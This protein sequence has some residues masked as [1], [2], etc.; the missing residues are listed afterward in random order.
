MYKKIPKSVFCK[1]YISLL[2]SLQ[3]VVAFTISTWQIKDVYPDVAYNIPL[4][5]VGFLL[6]FLALFSLITAFRRTFLIAFVYVLLL[7]SV[8]VI[9]YYELAL[10]GTVLTHQDIGNLTTAAGQ[11]NNYTF[12][13]TT[14]VMWILLSFLATQFFLL[15]IRTR[16]IEFEVNWKAG[17]I[18]GLGLVTIIY[19]LIYSPVSIIDKGNWSWERKFFIDSFIVGTLENIKVSS[20]IVQKPDGYSDESVLFSKD[21]Q[22]ANDKD[23]SY[24]DIIV[25]LNETYYD[26]NHL[27]DFESDVS[28]MENYDALDAYKGYAAVP[29]VGGGTNASEYELLTGNSMSLLNTSTPFN[30]MLFQGVH[31]MVSYLER[32][33]Y[34]TMAAHSE[35]SSNYHRGAA[36]IQLGFDEVFFSDDFIGLEKYGER[37]PS[38]DSSVFKN[39]IRFYNEMPD[40]KP[41]FAYLLTIQNHGGWESNSPE[42]DTVHIRETKGLS[43]EDFERMNEFLSC[44]KMTDDFIAE[45]TDYF[46]SSDRDVVLYMVGDHCPSFLAG[47]T[48]KTNADSGTVLDACTEERV[49]FRKRQVPYFIWSNRILN[50]S[51]MPENSEIDMCALSAYALKYARLPLSPYYSQLIKISQDSKC[52]TKIEANYEGNISAGYI[53][54]DDKIKSINGMTEPATQIRN[55]FYMEYNSFLNSSRIEEL[56]NP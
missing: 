49:T 22:D 33:G 5:L 56:F 23:Y 3:V 13:L 26:I 32:F 43:G 36:W 38:T 12:R 24:P 42:L 1:L 15:V 40:D 47:L 11:L 2:C 8:A 19:F 7:N 21:E 39:F 10:H 41:R 27:A 44:I 54:T 29:Y 4:Y 30:D 34:T 16:K 31:S 35:P 17:M 55:Y 51:E 20:E 28:Y 6:S 45:M 52:F 37:Y 48:P 53:G 14:S 9:N 46:S 25:I 18:S 50:N